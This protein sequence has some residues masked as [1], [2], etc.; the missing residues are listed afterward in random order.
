M[1][2]ICLI[3][4][5]WFQVLA[6]VGED[7]QSSS[8]YKLFNELLVG[9]TYSW[10]SKILQHPSGGC[11]DKLATLTGLLPITTLHNSATSTFTIKVSFY[12]IAPIE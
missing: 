9:G 3:F 10:V 4:W 8:L 2:Q 7:C 5:F 11:D 1:P 6:T 12:S